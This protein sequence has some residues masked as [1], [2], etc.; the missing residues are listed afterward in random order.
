MTQTVKDVNPEIWR[1]FAGLCKIK[2]IKIGNEL[3]K[4]LEDYVKKNLK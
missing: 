2:G 4:V 3:T 1:R